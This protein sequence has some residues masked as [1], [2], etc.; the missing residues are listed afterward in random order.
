MK[1][2]TKIPAR[3]FRCPEG[4]L[5]AEGK[6]ASP[7]FCYRIKVDIKKVKKSYSMLKGRVTV[8]ELHSKMTG[9]KMGYLGVGPG[10]IAK[11][12]EGA[13]RWVESRFDH[14]LKP[15]D[16]PKLIDQKMQQF[17]KAGQDPKGAPIGTNPQFLHTANDA[18]KTLMREAKKK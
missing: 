15:F 17:I 3:K 5:K 1:V 16:T 14:A 12:K 9:R 2:A 6:S 10:F 11:D 4:K 18:W 8:I 7:P 13:Q